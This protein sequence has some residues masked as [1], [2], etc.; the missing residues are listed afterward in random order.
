MTEWTAFEEN[1]LYPDCHARYYFYPFVV[2]PDVEI[3][4]EGEY[5]CSRYMSYTVYGCNLQVIATAFDQMLIPNDG[6]V[7]TFEPY[8][9]WQATNRSYTLKLQFI[10]P[11]QYVCPFVPGIG[12][13]I[14]FVGALPNGQLNSWGILVYRI[15]VASEG[16]DEAGGAL[17]KI[18]YR[19]IRD[20]KRLR[21]KNSKP[22][23]MKAILQQSNQACC[24]PSNPIANRTGALPLNTNGLSWTRP[25]YKQNLVLLGN[26]Q[27]GYIYAPLY[28]SPTQYLCLRWKAPTFPDTYHNQSITGLENMRY[29]SMSFVSKVG[30]ATICTVADYQT[31][32]D[33]QGFATLVVGFGAP[34]PAFAIPEHG[35][36]WID[37]GNQPVKGVIYRNMVVSACFPCTAVNIPFGQQVSMQMGEYL[38]VGQYISGN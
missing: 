15:Y 10:P 26:P 5:P 14:F 32:L 27:G 17:P 37:L 20:G 30:T 19:R 22:F 35:Y 3:I 6:C 34:R 12:N 18:T 13:N 7:N 38:P 28:S 2:D 16:A 23:D 11:P 31:V 29:W 25:S 21:I 4:I 8:A 24:M 36:T 9:N 33:E 1:A